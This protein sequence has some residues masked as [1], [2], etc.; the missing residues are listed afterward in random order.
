[1]LTI[2]ERVYE[3]S[4][5]TH[6][7]WSLWGV[8]G[9][10]MMLM[11]LAFWAVVIVGLVVGIRFMLHLGSDTRRDPALDVLRQRY[12]RGEITKDEFEAK[13]RDLTA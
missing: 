1:M 3:W 11:M 5:Y 6:P 10:G 9:L 8:W 4:W 2:Q 12:A 7:V 13:R